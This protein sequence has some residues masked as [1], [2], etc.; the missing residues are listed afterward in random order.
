LMKK[1]EKHDVKEVALDGVKQKGKRVKPNLL[2]R[3]VPQGKRDEGTGKKGEQMSKGLLTKKRK[4]KKL[5]LRA[6]ASIR[7]KQKGRGKNRLV[8][9]YLRT[10]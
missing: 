3:R 1:T 9:V 2:R 8:T 5:R 6:A 10:Q 4:T 7:K